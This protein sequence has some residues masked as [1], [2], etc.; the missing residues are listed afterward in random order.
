MNR[1]YFT[2]VALGAALVS[3][4]AAHARDFDHLLKGPFSAVFDGDMCRLAGRI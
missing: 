4:S 2:G 1:G 3:I